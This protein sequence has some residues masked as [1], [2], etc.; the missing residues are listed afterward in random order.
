MSLCRIG[1]IFNWRD[2]TQTVQTR[3]KFPTTNCILPGNNL[4]NS[5]LSSSVLFC[6]LTFQ[7][8]VVLVFVLRFPKCDF[9]VKVMCGQKEQT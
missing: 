5:H 6:K 9:G 7:L 3:A 2:Y 4:L 1:G 8:S